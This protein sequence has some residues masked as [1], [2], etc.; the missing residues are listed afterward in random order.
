MIHLTMDVLL[1][2]GLEIAKHTNEE[3]YEVLISSSF[4]TNQYQGNEEKHQVYVLAENDTNEDETK[5][6]EFLT[7]E[8]GDIY[9]FM[10]NKLDGTNGKQLQVSWRRQQSDASDMRARK[11]RAIGGKSNYVGSAEINR[12]VISHSSKDKKL[13]AQIGEYLDILGFNCFVVRESCEGG[14]DWQ[15]E[16]N[17]HLDEMKF[18]IPLLTKSFSRSVSCHQECGFACSRA[19]IGRARN[20]GNTT[21]VRII[22]L[23]FGGVLP[24]AMMASVYA[25]PVNI[26]E[27]GKLVAKILKATGV[28]IF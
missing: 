1:Q 6:A 9:K 24:P 27:P 5:V 7:G 26:E 8:L 4:L 3:V 11:F 28:E 16:I 13:A 21:A 20:H 22:P 10:T 15:D 19:G 14:S 23:S 17:L 2:L 12:V 18:F 25:H